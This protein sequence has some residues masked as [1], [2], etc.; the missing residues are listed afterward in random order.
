VKS[1]STLIEFKTSVNLMN[2][3]SLMY[4]LEVA[5]YGSAF[6]YI[7]DMKLFFSLT[8]LVMGLYAR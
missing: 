4:E 8:G 7:I 2:S 3:L 6:T 1:V 5:L